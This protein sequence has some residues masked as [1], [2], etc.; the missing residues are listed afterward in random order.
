[1]DV[2]LTASVSVLPV[3]PQGLTVPVCPET[4]E[5]TSTRSGGVIPMCPLGSRGTWCS[6]GKNRRHWVVESS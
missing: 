3:V 4:E 1:M 5:E 6:R 2:L